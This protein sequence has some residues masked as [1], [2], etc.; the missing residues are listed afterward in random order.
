[1]S[2]TPLEFAANF[3]TLVC[4]FLA[5][6]NNVHT[7]WTGI[8]ACILFGALCLDLRLGERIDARNIRIIVFL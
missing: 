7:W 5:G 3:M 6:R 1:M 2:W 8:V 4:I